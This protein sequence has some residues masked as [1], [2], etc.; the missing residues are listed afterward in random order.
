MTKGEVMA[1]KVCFDLPDGRRVC[2]PLYVEVQRKWPWPGPDPDPGPYRF[3]DLFDPRVIPTIEIDGEPARWAQ[4]VARLSAVAD[5]VSTV[6]DDTVR[7]VLQSQVQDLG[8]QL[9]KAVEGAE[10]HL[11]R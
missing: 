4:D 6:E 11:G 1:S 3:S 8:R 7:D 9:A 10:V 5:I 2:I